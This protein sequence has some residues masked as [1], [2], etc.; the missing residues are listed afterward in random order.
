MKIVQMS[1]DSLTPY[2]G[3]PRKITE[4]AV[5]R[6]AESIRRYGWQ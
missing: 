6:V 5:D 2:P 3:N 1:P 4:E